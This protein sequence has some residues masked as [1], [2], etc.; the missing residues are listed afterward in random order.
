[1]GF[2]KVLV[3]KSWWHHLSGATTLKTVPILKH[4]VCFSERSSR[5]ENLMMI[6][7]MIDH[8]H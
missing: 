3:K 7:I 5:P 2:E 6:G 1:M 8:D 4:N